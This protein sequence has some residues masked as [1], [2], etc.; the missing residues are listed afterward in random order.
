MV[1]AEHIELWNLTQCC[2]DFG[3]G[4]V[5]HIAYV[6]AVALKE[7]GFKRQYAVQAGYILLYLLYTIFL[8][9]PHLR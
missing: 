4:G 1:A 9:C 8:P 7:F 6:V 2:I 5:A 3:N